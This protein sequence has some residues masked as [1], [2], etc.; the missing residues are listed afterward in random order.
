[1]PT[2][3]YVSKT[4]TLLIPGK[5]HSHALHILKKH[6]TVVQTDAEMPLPTDINVINDIDALTTFMHPVDAALLDGLPNLKIIASF[7][8]GYDH[9][10]AAYAARKNIMV[11]HTPDVLDD[12]VADT[13]VG[14]LIS[15]L[16]ELPKAEKWLRDGNWKTQG[17]YPLTPLTLRSRTVGI[18]GLGRIGQAIATRLEAFG[19]TIHYHNRSPKPAVTYTYHASL[20]D[21]ANAVDTLISVVPGTA[22]TYQAVNAEVL[23]ALGNKGVL[24]NVGRGNAVDEHA[25]A[26]ALHNGTIAA[27]GLDVFADEPNVAE[28]LLSAPNTVLLPHIASASE[29]TRQAMANL[30]LDNLTSWFDGNG[31]VTPTP[32]CQ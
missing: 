25:L 27:A 24:I 1:M 16:R 19:V 23:S 4:P 7:G 20:M 22:A 30:V 28:A 3:Q 5:A 8:V 21:M 11:T 6:F 31:A 32:E 10:D 17:S 18:F 12:E 9:I 13:T 26:A 29:H 15:T 2:K 14:M